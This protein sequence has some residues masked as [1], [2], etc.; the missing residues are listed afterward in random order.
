MKKILF[1]FIVILSAC[2]PKIAPPVQPVIIYKT[3]TDTVVIERTIEIGSPYIDTLSFNLLAVCDSL[4]KGLI[5][6]GYQK[7]TDPH[8]IGKSYLKI[9]SLG[10]ASVF[11]KVEPYKVKIDSLQQ[12]TIKQAQQIFSKDEIERQVKDR[13]SFYRAGF[14]VTC[15]FLSLVLTG[16]IFKK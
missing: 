15:I 1:F 8:H 16:L 10:I 11:C 4:Q 5:K 2:S 14:I 12:I 9:D 6:N 3:D 7:T 13:A